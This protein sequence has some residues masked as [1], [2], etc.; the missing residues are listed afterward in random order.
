VSA[1]AQ[2]ES[3]LR[4]R[5]GRIIAGCAER[6]GRE[7]RIGDQAERAAVRALP[8]PPL[9]AARREP[10]APTP[11]PDRDRPRNRSAAVPD[12]VS[13]GAGTDLSLD[14]SPYTSTYDPSYTQVHN[15]SKEVA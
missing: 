6:A 15:K 12:R 9:P 5:F 1:P 11:S 7:L 2:T 10:R 14:Q 13:A 8:G 3:W 4:A